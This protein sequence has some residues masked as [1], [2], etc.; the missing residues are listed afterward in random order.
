MKVG[1]SIHA[2]L[3]ASSASRW[4]ACPGSVS[5]QDGHA[6]D[7]DGG[8][9]A[10]EGTAAHEVAARC[11][12]QGHDPEDYLGHEVT[13]GKR[14][15]EITRE[16]V[17][18]VKVYVDECERRKVAC[19]VFRVE[20]TFN[21]NSLMPP[22][23]MFGTADFVVYH[24][25]SRLLTVVDLK[26]GR[27]VLVD[28]EGNPQLRYYALGALLA[29]AKPVTTVKAIIV[30]PRAGGI[31]EAEFDAA[32]LIEWTADLLEAARRTQEKD[33]P[34][35]AG[36]WCRF[37]KARASCS[38][39]RRFSVAT[40]QA[41][42]DDG[43]LDKLDAEMVGPNSVSDA[44]LA[45]IL[46]RLDKVELWMRAVREEAFKR[47]NAGKEIAGWKVVAKRAR[48]QWTNEEAAEGLLDML[49]VSEDRIFAKKI[50]T[51]AQ[52]EKLVDK[53]QRAALSALTAAVS[54]GATLARSTDARPAAAGVSFDELPDEES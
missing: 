54:S 6:D 17:D 50:V 30:Q 23:P 39:L 52:A 40:T 32:E 33:A 28:A 10:A 21:L 3:S 4:M 12:A 20:Q 14:V 47:L 27:G 38:E 43:E 5:A 36:S 22:A 25:A 9:F 11:L 18:G 48:R 53:S 34:R 26:F 1:P 49:G 45:A 19:D 35:N 15:I 8:P 2:R 7:D 31:K 29:L 24:E 44:E 51:P 41:A 37:C 16:I 13:V 46:D 42:F